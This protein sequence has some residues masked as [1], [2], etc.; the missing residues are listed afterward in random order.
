MT[1]PHISLAAE[2]VLHIGTI[3]VTN[4][5]LTTWMVMAF[6]VIIA[7]YAGST[8]KRKPGYF[9]IAVEAVV[10][11]LFQF[12][13]SLGGKH[14]KQFTPLLVT[15][16]LYILICNWSGLLPG[17]GTIGLAPATVSSEAP[18]HQTKFVPLFRGPTADLNTTIALALIAFSLIQY[19]GFKTLGITYV[20]K[21]FNFGNPINTFIG[22]LEIVSDISKIISFAFRLFGNIFAGEVLL[23]VMAAFLPVFLPLPFLGL[24]VFVGVIQALVFAML[25]GV[26]INLAAVGHGEHAE[27]EERR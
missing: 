8:L 7:L 3:P 1:Q 27:A 4:S 17:V 10:G 15:F 6:L 23:V 20:K 26:F 25:T 5:F 12:L 9:Q 16:F 18:A 14:G 2:P 21:F 22:I 13:D 11:G 19:A 24:E